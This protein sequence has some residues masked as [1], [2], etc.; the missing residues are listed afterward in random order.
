MNGAQMSDN[1]TSLRPTPED[2]VV[3]R[4]SGTFDEAW[5]LQEYPDVAK[6]GMDAAEHYLWLGRRLG[7]A[8]VPPSNSASTASAFHF[9][10]EENL[11]SALYDYAAKHSACAIR[12]T[13]GA[14]I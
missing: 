9:G 6:A 8:G 10:A 12:M 13:R 1:S 11:S 3:L 7:R 14:G 2:I 4:A 5:Y